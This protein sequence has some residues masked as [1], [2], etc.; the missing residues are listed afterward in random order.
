ETSQRLD[1]LK[2]NVNSQIKSE[3]AI[4]NRQLAELAD[5]QNRIRSASNSGLVSIDLQDQRD[6]LIN[7]IA[8]KIDVTRIEHAQD[9]F[10]LTIGGNSISIGSVP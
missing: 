7:Q 4:V 1:E 3:V 5:L 8:E 9:G 2:G 6:Q 10:G